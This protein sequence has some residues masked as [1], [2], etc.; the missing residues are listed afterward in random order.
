[1][2]DTNATVEAMAAEDKR[3]RTQSQQR[4]YR[5]F[6]AKMIIHQNIGTTISAQLCDLQM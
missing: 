1:L 6:L 3:Q 4:N 5:S 2:R